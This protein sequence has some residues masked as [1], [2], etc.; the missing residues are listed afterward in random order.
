MR[1]RVD[2]PKVSAG[3]LLAAATLLLVTGCASGPQLRTDSAPGF[4]FSQATTFGF[5][6]DLSTNRGGYHS[7]VTQQ[8][9]FSTQREMEV[10]GFRRVDNPAD[11]DLLI[12][13]N[14]DVADTI[15]VR[16]TPEPMGGSQFWN[17]RRG[18]YSPWPG[19]TRWPQ[20]TRWPQDR[21]E[22]TQVT[23][24]ALSIDLVDAR[25]NMLVWEGVASQRLTQRTLND[26]GPALDSAVHDLFARFPV[27]P[28]L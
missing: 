28:T 19:H 2:S 1:T 22:V 25:R 3:L 8:L 20:P 18:M 27:A 11:A 14:A 5:F 7:L 23:E 9:K 24:G 4:D 16:S 17:H 12:N 6:D 21:V 13:F 26:L 10:R 15:R